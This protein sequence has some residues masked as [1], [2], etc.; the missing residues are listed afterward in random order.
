MS[1]SFIHVNRLCSILISGVLPLFLNKDFSFLIL[2]Q[3][4]LAE[5][6]FPRDLARLS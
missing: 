1:K 4:F 6:L 3:T 2:R 5:Y